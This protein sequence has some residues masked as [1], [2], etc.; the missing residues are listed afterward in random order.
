MKSQ[1]NKSGSKGLYLRPSGRYTVK[2]CIYGLTN[3]LGSYA[4]KEEA[5]RVYD[6]YVKKRRF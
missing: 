5:A 1:N 6:D 4:T 3:Y 2:V